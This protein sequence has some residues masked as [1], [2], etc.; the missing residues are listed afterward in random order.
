MA[1]IEL[2]LDRSKQRALP[3]WLMIVVIALIVSRVISSRYPVQ[4]DVDLVHWT[5]MEEAT[6]AAKKSHRPILY[7]F[8]AEWCAPCHQ[9]E[10]E[11]FMDPGMA[12]EINR[13]FIAVKV[14][15]RLRE[16]GRNAP[17]VQSLI[18]RYT[19]TAFPTTV[20]VDANGAVRDRM[21]GYTGSTK[22]LGFLY[23][24]R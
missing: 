7:E 16:N 24:I 1:P 23:R 15:D 19:I 12:G 22:F 21:V 9:L 10:R 14:I 18:D 4:K 6:A 5:P 17:D 11:V 20:A 8:S 2:T 13:R 3:L